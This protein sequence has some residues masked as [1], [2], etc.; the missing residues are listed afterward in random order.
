[1][2][3]NLFKNAIWCAMD[4]VAMPVVV[5]MALLTGEHD[6]ARALATDI[7]Y[8]ID[9]LIDAATEKVNVENGEG[10]NTTVGDDEGRG[11]EA[12]SEEQQLDTSEK[13]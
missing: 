13:C 6:K 2:S 7:Q 4:V 5:P 11:S 12:V 9:S 8:H 3:R 1:M 10:Y